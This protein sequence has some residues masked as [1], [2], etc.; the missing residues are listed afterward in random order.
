MADVEAPQAAHQE[1]APADVLSDPDTTGVTSEI[2][3]E[4]EKEA[5]PKEA[6]NGVKKENVLP[7][8]GIAPK[9]PGT[10]TTSSAAKP[11]TSSAT[12]TTAGGLSKPP[13]RPPVGSSVRKPASSATAPT[14]AS[15][16]HKSTPSTGGGP[17]M[18]KRSHLQQQLEEPPLQRQ[19]PIILL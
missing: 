2:E 5:P 11:A 17:A 6:T 4:T 7:K 1:E 15:A 14:S 10:T 3:T 18:R 12:R 16:G 8:R 9:R 19:A 13:T